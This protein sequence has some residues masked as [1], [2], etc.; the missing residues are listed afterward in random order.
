MTGIMYKKSPNSIS[1]VPK[2]PDLSLEDIDKGIL[3]LFDDRISLFTEIPDPKTGA[4]K[5]EKVPCV[6]VGGE[7][8]AQSSKLGR[9]G[10]IRDRDGKIM[11][12]CLSIERKD[13]STSMQDYNGIQIPYVQKKMV[14]RID[15]AKAERKMLTPN[16]KGI[17]IGK[18]SNN[19]KAPPMDFVLSKRPEYATINYKVTVWAS[20]MRQ[21]NQI[22]HLILQERDMPTFY[23]VQLDNGYR[24]EYKIKEAISNSSNIE[25]FIDDDRI[26]KNE[27]E[28]S[29]S[30]PLRSSKGST[31]DVEIIRSPRTLNFNIA[32]EG[33]GGAPIRLTEENYRQYMEGINNRIN[34]FQIVDEST[35][36]VEDRNPFTRPRREIESQIT[37]TMFSPQRVYALMMM[38]PEIGT[39]REMQY[40]KLG[41]KKARENSFIADSESI[42]KRIFN[43]RYVLAGSVIE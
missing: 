18:N 35:M 34:P 25:N 11:K 1:N 27:F 24:L 16:S 36:S 39:Y 6:F 15:T 14:Q 3:Q 20:F 2:S 10:E 33:M 43:G 19:V 5:N 32:I 26:I 13:I 9:Y 41:T 29:V 22:I 38:Y 31:D 37:N 8:F 40:S 12:P 4:I 21:M 23:Y 42:Y 17:I 30:A 28:L 7:R